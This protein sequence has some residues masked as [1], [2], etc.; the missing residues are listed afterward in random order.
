MDEEYQE[1]LRWKRDRDRDYRRKRSISNIL[2]ESYREHHPDPRRAAPKERRGSRDRNTPL[3]EDRRGK[4][5]R[6]EAREYDDEGPSSYRKRPRSQRRDRDSVSE[7]SSEGTQI[8][9]K[10]VKDK[11]RMVRPKRQVDDKNK[12]PLR[13]CIRDT[14]AKVQPTQSLLE[15]MVP[16]VTGGLT[17]DEIKQLQDISE[18]LPGWNTEAMRRIAE[19]IPHSDS[20]QE[21]ETSM[22][23]Q[24]TGFTA[25]EK[26]PNRERLQSGPRG[27][28]PIPD[29]TQ[30]TQVGAEVA[31]PEQPK[32]RKVRKMRHASTQSDA[33]P[34]CTLMKKASEYVPL[35]WQDFSDP[36]ET[37]TT[38]D[39]GG[40]TLTGIGKLSESGKDEVTSGRQMPLPLQEGAM[41]SLKDNFGCAI[42]PKSRPQETKGG[43]GAML[44]S[45]GKGSQ[46]MMQAPAILKGKDFGG[47]GQS[48]DG[49]LH[50]KGD[51]SRGFKGW[52]QPN[53][54]SLGATLGIRGY[55]TD[56]IRTPLYPKGKAG[57]TL[58]NKGAMKGQPIPVSK[59][60]GVAPSTTMGK[61][62][63]GKDIYGK[64]PSGVTQGKNAKAAM[65]LLP[66]SAARQHELL[67]SKG[68]LGKGDEKGDK[69]QERLLSVQEQEQELFHPP[70]DVYERTERYKLCDQKV[71]D[72]TMHLLQTNPNML[73]QSLR[74]W[75]LAGMRGTPNDRPISTKR[76]N[77][78]IYCQRGL[79]LREFVKLCGEKDLATAIHTLT[80]MKVGQK[81]EQHKE[82]GEGAALQGSGNKNNAGEAG[83]EK[84]TEPPTKQ[85]KGKRRDALCEE[86]S[87]SERKASGKGGKYG[88]KPSKHNPSQQPRSV[89]S[90]GK[91]SNKTAAASHTR[92]GATEN[93]VISGRA[94]NESTAEKC[95][96]QD[97][98]V[99]QFCKRQAEVKEIRWAV[100]SPM[101]TD[102]PCFPILQ[103]G[104]PKAVF[105]ESERSAQVSTTNTIKENDKLP[106]AELDTRKHEENTQGRLTQAAG[107]QEP[108]GSMV[109]GEEKIGGSDKIMEINSSKFEEENRLQT[110]RDHALVQPSQPEA[111]DK[112]DESR[113]ETVS[114]NGDCADASE[115]QVKQTTD[116]PKPA[117]V[118]AS[119]TRGEDSSITDEGHPA[120][121]LESPGVFIP[122]DGENASPSVI[123]EKDRGSV[124][125]S[126]GPA[127][128]LPLLGAALHQSPRDS[129]AAHHARISCNA[130]DQFHYALRREVLI[131]NIARLQGLDHER[132]VTLATVD[133]EDLDQ[134]SARAD[135]NVLEGIKSYLHEQRTSVIR[136]G[137]RSFVISLKKL[138]CR[139]LSIEKTRFDE[140]FR[141]NHKCSHLY[142]NYS[143][144]S[145]YRCP[146]PGCEG[147]TL[148]YVNIKRAVGAHNKTYHRQWLDVPLTY[149]IE[150]GRG[151]DY[152]NCGSLEHAGNDIRGKSINL[153]I[154]KEPK[155]LPRNDT[156]EGKM[157]NKEIKEV[158]HPRPEVQPLK[159]AILKWGGTA[160]QCEE[161]KKEGTPQ[162][163]Y[164]GMG[165]YRLTMSGNE[166]EAA[167]PPTSL[168]TFAQGPD[169]N[170][171]QNSDSVGMPTPE[172][173]E[174]SGHVDGSNATD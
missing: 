148:N 137:G 48:M 117:I 58:P 149:K 123:G 114:S 146:L 15:H 138:P 79:L 115:S 74:I 88:K 162:R 126:R 173:I 145:I 65:P 60:A 35:T 104:Q 165:V 135:L 97:K 33:P 28:L 152:L 93:A 151:W 41:G 91:E 172:I 87:F 127:E 26:G 107:R 22:E 13:V 153:T 163:T 75:I 64:G 85:S 157:L 116:K 105:E 129:E 89:F 141:N 159:Q 155:S 124:E 72:H 55:Q 130:I 166:S 29:V 47:K 139:I 95:T 6:K 121:T 161:W 84:K 57:L 43:L 144:G 68:R 132:L 136:W 56:P 44:A 96:N 4:K 90:K 101:A 82:S 112:S 45:K 94:T 39:G 164:R 170:T 169:L 133:G 99:D 7:W 52:M 168:T 14:P 34:L 37:G 30:P 134:R 100:E 103:G 78:I 77:H 110:V 2:E 80:G 49:F 167:K 36:S 171:V 42:P 40:S 12:E 16:G 5:D 111:D 25:E 8:E 69:G 120:G 21:M 53:P 119:E 70:P 92:S 54:S 46:V 102:I 50:P 23:E 158:T 128:Q 11:A 63:K 32:L 31:P 109:C 147:A 1:Y 17:Q 125:L 106:L 140:L 83:E 174:K 142:T 24:K 19:R 118:I 27:G 38:G 131:Q 122:T 20:A 76:I 98:N 62:A 156:H 86:R 66:F 113:L 51:Q 10:E 160:V 108:D 81:N 67:D 143:K 71:R 59:M 73:R 61:T 9:A 150:M 18:K 3:M 154:G